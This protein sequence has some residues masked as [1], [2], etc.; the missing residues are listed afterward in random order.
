[1]FY[2]ITKEFMCIWQY[3]FFI[4]RGCTVHLYIIKVFFIFT[5]GCT[6]CLLRST[7]KFTLKLLLHVW[8]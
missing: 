5:N 7:L 8:V 4:F 6:I 2:I 1:M 3:A